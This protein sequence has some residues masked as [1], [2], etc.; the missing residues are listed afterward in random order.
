MLPA[1]S[2]D[3]AGSARIPLLPND[4]YVVDA[5]LDEAGGRR[6]GRLDPQLDGLAGERADVDASRSPRHRRGW[7]PR[8]AWLNTTVAFPPTTTL[9]RKKS[10]EVALFRCARYHENDSVCVPPAG[11]A[12][13]GDWMLVVAAVDVVRARARAGGEPGDEVVGAADGRAELQRDAAARGLRVTALPTR[14]SSAVSVPL[15]LV[16]Q[17]SAVSNVVREDV[18]P[19]GCWC[20]RC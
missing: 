12:I 4:N 13:A 1:P 6:V 5:G 10:A 7:L 16:V 19:G 17:P 9:T 3:G 20:R 11:S 15:G 18:V 8:R 14:P 2:R